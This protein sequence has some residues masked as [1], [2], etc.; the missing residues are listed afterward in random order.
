MASAMGLG[1]PIGVFL[2][3]QKRKSKAEAEAPLYAKVFEELT[4]GQWDEGLWFR[5]LAQCNGDE[6]QAQALYSRI[7]VAQLASEAQK[8]SRLP[9]ASVDGLPS[10]ADFYCMCLQW[11]WPISLLLAWNRFLTTRNIIHETVLPSFTVPGAS[12][13]V[14]VAEV[15]PFIA[16]WIQFDLLLRTI[17]TLPRFLQNSSASLSAAAFTG[18]EAP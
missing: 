13:T 11:G 14:R 17:M 16:T 15:P 2:L 12:R 3:W 9:E 18:P 8:A 5:S 7:R 4:K 1:V 10:E 6:K